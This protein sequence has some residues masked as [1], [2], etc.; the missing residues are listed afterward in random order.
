MACLEIRNA[1][2]EDI[3]VTVYTSA[4]GTFRVRVAAVDTEKIYKT[5][6][7]CVPAADYVRSEAKFVGDIFEPSR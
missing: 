1:G 4:S 3:E 7:M 5:G 2:R 6:R